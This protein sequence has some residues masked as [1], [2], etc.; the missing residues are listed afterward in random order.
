MAGLAQL[1]NRLGVVAEILLA[2]NEND[3]KALAEMQ[4]LGDPLQKEEHVL[5]I[6]AYRDATRVL[7]D[8]G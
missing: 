4:N 2:A 1:F 7:V 6:I 5:A 3:R 8:K